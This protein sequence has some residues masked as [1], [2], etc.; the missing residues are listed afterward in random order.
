MKKTNLSNNISLGFKKQLPKKESLDPD[1]IDSMT[2]KIHKKGEKT[3]RVTIDIPETQYLQM[4]MKSVQEKKSVRQF[5]LD[6]LYADLD[7]PINES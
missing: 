7:L 6:L 5:F 1:K 4:K 3:V 2:K